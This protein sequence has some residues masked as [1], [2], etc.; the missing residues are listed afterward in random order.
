MILAVVFWLITPAHAHRPGISYAEVTPDAVALTFAKPE[1]AAIAPVEDIDA[2][3]ILIAEGTLGKTTV[4]QDGQPCS[5]GEP[6]V[7]EVAGDGVE[8]RAPLT[9]PA[10]ESRTFT[11]DYLDTLAPGHRAFLQGE[12]NPVAVLDVAA[13]SASFSMTAAGTEQVAVRF[14]GLGMEHIWTGYDHLAFLCALLLAAASLRQMLLIVTGFT[15]AHSITLSLAATGIFT[16]PPAIVEPA[17]ALT[18]LLVGIENLWKPTARR[19]VVTTCTLGLI[20]GF[21]FAGLLAQLGLPRDALALALVCFNGGVEIGQ[22]AVVAVVLPLLLW[23]RRRPWWER[24]AVPV[25]SI[26]IACAGLYWFVDRVFLGG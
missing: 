7:T 20:H 16:L 21:G 3:R 12:G 17:I 15:I 23:M 5:L 9:C 2:S 19:R 1:L 25:L 26:A 10:G 14:L 11:A 6:T 18:I 24:R 13:R 22:A 8:V 4:T